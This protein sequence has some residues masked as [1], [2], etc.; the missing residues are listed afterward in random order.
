M[1]AYS[2]ITTAPLLR[3]EFCGQGCISDWLA[4]ESSVEP[5]NAARVAAALATHEDFA[6]LLVA[7][8]AAAP[9]RAEIESLIDDLFGDFSSASHTPMAFCAECDEPRPI[10]ESFIVL[11]PG[12]AGGRGA[13]YRRVLCSLPC[14]TASLR[15][16]AARHR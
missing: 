13:R 6:R 2:L 11:S 9:H 4:S 7:S 15:A 3:H 12:M 1:T 10:A 16:D 14:L 8:G 5:I